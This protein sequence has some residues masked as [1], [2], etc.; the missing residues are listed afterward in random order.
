MEKME[1][2]KRKK[3]RLFAG[4]FS[5]ISREA[6]AFKKKRGRLNVSAISREDCEVPALKKKKKKK[7]L[8][9]SLAISR[10][11]PFS[12]RPKPRA[13]FLPH[14]PDLSRRPSSGF[15]GYARLQGY[16]DRSGTRVPAALS[17]SSLSP[18]IF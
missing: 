9:V 15:W 1:R 6:P 4:Q 17:A 11:R 14:V 7:R 2:R 12:A 16:G 18:F 5:A 13:L 8:N 3:K 10:E